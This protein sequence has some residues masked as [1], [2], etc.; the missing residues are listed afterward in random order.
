MAAPTPTVRDTPVGRKLTNGYKAFVTFAS[1]PDIGFW[2]MEVTPPGL[3]GGDEIDTTT[4]HNETVV[5][6]AP[7]SPLVDVT[8]GEGTAA[9]DPASF[10]AIRAL[11]NVPTTVTYRYP[12]GDTMAVYGFLKK[13]E[14]QGLQRGEMPEA[15]FEVVHTNEDPD[16]GEEELPV[17]TEFT[18]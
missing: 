15:E 5:T 12:N 1:A 14:K 2:E 3:E 9:Y 18:G 10:D 8:N 11:I 16:T 7:N 17:I 13:F 6:K 4:M